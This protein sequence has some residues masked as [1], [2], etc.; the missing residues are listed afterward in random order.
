MG[1]GSRPVSEVSGLTLLYPANTLRPERFLCVYVKWREV[2]F[3]NLVSEYRYDASETAQN[4]TFD[5]MHCGYVCIVDENAKVLYHAGDVEDFVFYRSASKP[6]QSL[7]V[8]QYHLDEK[9]GITEKES[10]VF[11]AS[12]IGAPYH[13]EA[14][15]SIL[16]KMGYTEDILCMNPAAPGDPEVNEERIRRGIPKR[17][18]FH[19]CSGKHCALLAVQTHLGGVPADYWKT[20]TPVFYETQKAIRTVSEADEVRIGVDGCGV[21]VFAVPVRNVAVSY[22]NLA[23]PDRI[24]DDALAA[25]AAENT[26]R[27]S[28]H[29]EMVRGKG[30]L[31]TVMNED[32]NIIAKDG[33]NGIFAFGLKKQRM[34]AAIKFT[35][36]TESGCT[37]LILEILRAL[38]ALTPELEARLMALQPILYTND[39]DRIVGERRCEIRIQV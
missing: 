25:A 29:P 11:S 34:G 35:D 22:K 30:Y 21:P 39:N 19:N 15:E 38:D 9:Y 1:R 37:L 20:G 7:P 26:R 2:M 33:V 3:A 18:V 14:V 13:V 4:A 12:H 27:I 5:L 16:A 8:F 10:A 28:Q 32:P 24:R 17:K 31:T 23:C 36:G 6:I